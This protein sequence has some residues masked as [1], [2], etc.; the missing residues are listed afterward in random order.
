MIIAVPS[1]DGINI[2]NGMLGMA[3]S[4]LIFQITH[5][6]HIKL[7]EKRYNP[8]EKT[9]QHMKTIDIYNILDDCDVILSSKIG[10]KGI[11]RLERKNI[12]LIFGKGKIEERLKQFAEGSAKNSQ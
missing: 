10:K 11:S 7:I 2:F 9:L 4:F 6:N 1:N 3:K 8:Y 12:K 5:E